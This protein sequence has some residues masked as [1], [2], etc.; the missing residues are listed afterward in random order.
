MI[1]NPELEKLKL[2]LRD[3]VFSNPLSFD[4]FL[5]KI[6]LSPVQRQIIIL[7]FVS[8]E[9]NGLRG[10]KEIEFLLDKS[11]DYVQKQYIKSLEI[12][13]NNLF[14]YIYSHLPNTIDSE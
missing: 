2:R 7:R 9:H 1:K 5:K 4:V 14:P 6:P 12:I 11:H 3:W 8:T 13:Q 10:F